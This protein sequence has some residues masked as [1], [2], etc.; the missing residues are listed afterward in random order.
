MV[1]SLTIGISPERLNCNI[2]EGRPTL[3]VHG[4]I[5]Q[6]GLRLKGEKENLESVPMFTSPCFLTVGTVT[7]CPIPAVTPGAAVTISPPGH[8]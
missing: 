1:L 3:D 5:P 8:D 7:S 6:A 4:T 2:Q